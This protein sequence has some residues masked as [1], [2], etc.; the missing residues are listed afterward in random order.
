M[1]LERICKAKGIE[2]KLFS[3]PRDL[4]A[5]CGIAWKSPAAF[6]DQVREVAAEAALEIHAFYVMEV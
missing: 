2:G 4:S 6:Q 5:D 1:A 3:A